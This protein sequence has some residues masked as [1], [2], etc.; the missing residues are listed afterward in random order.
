MHE[1]ILF[2]YK[3]YKIKLVII[4]LDTNYLFKDSN[5]VLIK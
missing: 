5:K 1:F 3:K 4:V 2:P